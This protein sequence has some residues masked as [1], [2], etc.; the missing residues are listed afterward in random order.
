[1]IE[2][3]TYPMALDG[4]RAARRTP[5]P[6]GTMESYLRLPFIQPAERLAAGVRRLAAIADRAA[7]GRPSA[8]PGWL[9]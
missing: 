2:C 3:P 9:T 4:V 6:D 8:V 5:A 1:M 7:A